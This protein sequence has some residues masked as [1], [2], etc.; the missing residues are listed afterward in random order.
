MSGSGSACAKACGGKGA[1]ETFKVKESLSIEEEKIRIK[2]S[3]KIIFS[4][5]NIKEYISGS[6]CAP[7]PVV[8][9]LRQCPLKRT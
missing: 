1:L 3:K 8:G 6:G 7:K 4:E 9:R 2:M 5:N